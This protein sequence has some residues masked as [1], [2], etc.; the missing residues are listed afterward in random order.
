MRLRSFLLFALFR[1]DEPPV[2]THDLRP[3]VGNFEMRFETYIAVFFI[4]PAKVRA[5]LIITV[6]HL[7]SPYRQYNKKG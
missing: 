6:F 1:R 7:I 4:G 3:G 5:W 2:A